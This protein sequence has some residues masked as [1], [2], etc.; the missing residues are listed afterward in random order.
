MRQRTHVAIDRISGGAAELRAEDPLDDVGLLFS[1]DHFGPGASVELVVYN[2]S[3]QP[4]SPEDRELLEAVIRDL[5]EGII[6]IGGLTS[7]GYGTLS[8]LSDIKWEDLAQ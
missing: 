8:L 6:G 3:R 1:I 7:R 4:V 2:D 5:N